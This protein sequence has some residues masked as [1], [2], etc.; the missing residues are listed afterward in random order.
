MR[1]E[2][3]MMQYNRCRD[4]ERENECAKAAIY[5]AQIMEMIAVDRL[6][7]SMKA[8]PGSNA[9]KEYAKACRMLAEWTGQTAEETDKQ[10]RKLRERINV[11]P[12]DRH[13]RNK[14]RRLKELCRTCRREIR[15]ECKETCCFM[16][17][18]SDI[19]AREE[20]GLW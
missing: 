14:A 20:G 13:Q 3:I 18:I 6:E 4:T 17:H 2:D 19:L 16:K 9:P 10:I 1:Y 12:A 8:P 11:I 15:G 5:T 7:K